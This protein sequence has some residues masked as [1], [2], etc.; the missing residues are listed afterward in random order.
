[1]V[2]KT[3]WHPFKER[4]VAEEE[5]ET[6]LKNKQKPKKKTPQKNQQNTT[7]QNP[8]QVWQ[9]PAIP[10]ALRRLRQRNSQFTGT[11]LHSKS[12]SIKQTKN[13]EIQLTTTRQLKG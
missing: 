2:L 5:K 7:P 13:P 1:M 3:P 12:V 6:L 11:D 10:A 8:S 4:E 9:M